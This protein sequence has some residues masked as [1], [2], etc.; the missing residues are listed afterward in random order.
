MHACLPA[1]LCA[2]SVL[3]LTVCLCALGTV[4]G[5]LFHPSEAD[6]LLSCSAAGSMVCSHYRQAAPEAGLSGARGQSGGVAPLLHEPGG[7]LVGMDWHPPSNDVLV[8]SSLGAVWRMECVT[9][10]AWEK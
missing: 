3:C 8:A 1:L 4:T 9:R 10:Y 7:T 6:A 5:V 2:V